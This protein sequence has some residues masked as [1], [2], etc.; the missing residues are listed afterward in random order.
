MGT[1]ICVGHRLYKDI[2]LER[3][4][5]KLEDRIL[6]DLRKKFPKEDPCKDKGCGR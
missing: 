4:A 5:Q 1:T 6:D 2:W 3:G